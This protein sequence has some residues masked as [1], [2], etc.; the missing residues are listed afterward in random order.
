VALTGKTVGPGL[1]ELMS[2]LGPV[3]MVQRLERAKRMLP[4]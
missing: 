4:E 3:R 2:V 1:F